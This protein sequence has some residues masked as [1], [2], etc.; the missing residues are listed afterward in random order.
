[1][2]RKLPGVLGATGVFLGIVLVFAWQ[3]I[4]TG[5]V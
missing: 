1:M 4:R 2:I 5:G 3:A